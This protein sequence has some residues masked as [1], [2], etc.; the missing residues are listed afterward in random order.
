[1]WKNTRTEK[2]NE[3]GGKRATSSM[4]TKQRPRVGERQK[5]TVGQ[6][7]RRRGKKEFGG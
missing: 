6:S 1:M 3:K 7:Q 4:T 2:E 5:E